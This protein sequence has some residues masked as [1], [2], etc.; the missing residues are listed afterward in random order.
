MRNFSANQ[1]INIAIALS[2]E[3][4]IDALLDRILTE[5]VDITNSDGGTVY[6]L[7]DGKLCFQNV[8]TRSKGVH[9]VRKGSEHLLPPVP[10]SETHV[11]ACAALRRRLINIPDV[12]Q[13]TLYDFSGPRRYDQ[14][15]NYHTQ[16]MLVVPMEDEQG[17]CIGVLQLINAQDEA[18][19]IIP[20]DAEYESIIRALGSLATVSLNNNRLQRAVSDI[21]HSFVMVMVDAVDARSPYNANHTRNMVTKAQRFIQWLNS[22]DHGWRFTEEEI[23]PFLMSVW[24]HDIG[25]LVVPLE[26]MDKQ[27]RLGVLEERVMARIEVAVLMERIRALDHPEEE[28][29]ATEQMQALTMARETILRANVAG[30][31]DQGLLDQVNALKDMCCMASDGRSIPLL[32]PEEFKALTVRKGTLTQSERAEMERHVVYTRRLLNNMKFSGSYSMVPTWASA[33]HE[34]LDGSGYPDHIKADQ[35]PREVRL[36]TILD[37]Y[38]ALTAEDRPYKRPIPP[39]RAFSILESMCSEGKMDREILMLF[40]ES[41]AWRTASAG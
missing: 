18:G 9:L 39:E 25:K 27:T 20:F 34:Y 26:I 23:D 29:S 40:R 22:G 35:L 41:E 10:M 17:Q 6:I 28:T 32:T 36:L 4:Q 24:L 33:H 31:L 12:Y 19:S 11:C 15:N 8:I 5:A 13:S 37:V 14:F 30:F 3:K 16:S 38:D 2:T 1:L 21:L 7:E